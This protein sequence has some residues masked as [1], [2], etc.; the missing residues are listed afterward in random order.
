MIRRPPSPT[1]TDPLFPYTTLFR[2]P[3]HGIGGGGH[4]VRPSRA[5]Q[6]GAD[7]PGAAA[8]AGISRCR[9]LP[10]DPSGRAD[11]RRQLPGHARGRRPAGR[12]LG[13]RGDRR[14]YGV[15]EGRSEEHTSE[16][17][18]IMRNSY[19]V[20]CLKKKNK[21]KS[22][23]TTHNENTIDKVIYIISTRRSN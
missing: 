2:S 18:S 17:Q 16:L 9:G 1:R 21:N 10:L 22:T 11:R 15:H 23:L 20:I 4:P 3:R 5:H 14:L 8:A 6:V 7:G 12:R 13:G 19:A